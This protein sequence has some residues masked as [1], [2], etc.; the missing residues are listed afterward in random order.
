MYR[1]Q[2]GGR[3][4]T[5]CGMKKI[6]VPRGAIR[7]ASWA[8]R[9]CLVDQLGVPR[10]K[11]GCGIPFE[12]PLVKRGNKEKPPLGGI[13]SKRRDYYEKRYLVFCCYSFILRRT[14]AVRVGR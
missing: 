10:L 8:I 13:A 1:L 7:C 12:A 6:G 11:G 5:L 2:N 4:M 3:N 9:A 14:Q